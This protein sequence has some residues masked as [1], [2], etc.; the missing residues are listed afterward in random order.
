LPV[1]L[2]PPQKQA[3]KLLWS[4]WKN[5]TLQFALVATAEPLLMLYKKKDEV[6][7]AQRALDTMRKTV[8]GF[9]AD[10]VCIG[11]LAAD[12]EQLVVT[13]DRARCKGAI[14]STDAFKKAWKAGAKL[15][16]IEPAAPLIDKASFG[17]DAAPPAVE[18]APEP[19]PAAK[20]AA[21]E[22]KPR[23]KVDTQA[24]KAA[25]RA[26]VTDLLTLKKAMERDF[27][28][29]PELKPA[30]ARLTGI[31]TQLD[32]GLL[33]TLEQINVL[34]AEEARRQA[35]ARAVRTIAEIRDYVE[36][37]PIVAQAER[38]PNGFD[39]VVNIKKPVRAALAS[40]LV[41]LR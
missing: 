24:W 11:T 2:T 38:Q 6:P 27:P 10:V 30:V 3:T 4:T 22:A 21:P 12:G 29:A 39:V 37:D 31:G 19:K 34:A 26:V 32:R 36:K 25:Q 14:P 41:S 20:P 35:I 1:S 40:I 16:G 13:I 5:T 17:A 33:A 15:A 8:T 18:P 23:P 28:D 9:K 7:S